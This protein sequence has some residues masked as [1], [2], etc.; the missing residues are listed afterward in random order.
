MSNKKEIYPDRRKMLI[1]LAG[2]VV[3]VTLSWS[4]ISMQAGLTGG[5]RVL[6]NL[7]YVIVVLFSWLGLYYAFRLLIPKPMIIFDEKGLLDQTSTFGVGRIPWRDVKT[8]FP[9]KAGNQQFLGIDLHHP[10]QYLQKL[11]GLKKTMMMMNLK[12]GHPPVKLPVNMMQLTLPQ[13]EKLATTYWK[14]Q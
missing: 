5:W 4:I 14:Q 1:S 8:I 11:A 6:L 10:E 12:V 9:L 7:A 2:S 13:L 3:M